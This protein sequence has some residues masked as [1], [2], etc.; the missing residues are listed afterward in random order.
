MIRLKICCSALRICPA[1]WLLPLRLLAV[2]R[3]LV[4]AHRVGHVVGRVDERVH[5]GEHLQVQPA[6]LVLQHLVHAVL[7]GP[8]EVDELP[9]QPEVVV[10]V[11]VVRVDEAV[12]QRLVD[13]V[14]VRVLDGVVLPRVLG[15]R[16]DQPGIDDD[17]ALGDRHPAPAWVLR[18]RAL[19]EVGDHHE[20][21][22]RLPVGRDVR[23]RGVGRQ[24]AADVPGRLV[25]LIDVARALD[26]PPRRGLEL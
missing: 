18:A 21:L 2:G 19:V 10:V 1:R 9:D 16:I 6:V 22:G 20:V 24:L 14:A 17:P 11:G 8:L 15:A 25:D 12:D 23:D 5:R 3:E 13:D 7:R 4:V 26:H